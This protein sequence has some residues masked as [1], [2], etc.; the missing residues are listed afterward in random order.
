[1]FL[2]ILVVL[3]EADSD[4]RGQNWLGNVQNLKETPSEKN[5]DAKKPADKGDAD[6][7]EKGKEAADKSPVTCKTD[8]A[9]EDCKEKFDKIRQQVLEFCKE[10]PGQAEKDCRSE[11]E[12][13]SLYVLPLLAII[14]GMYF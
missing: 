3:G 11:L 5:K 7:K 1:M 14:M 4:S 2:C 10:F 6:K 13:A 12:A 8:D 9:P